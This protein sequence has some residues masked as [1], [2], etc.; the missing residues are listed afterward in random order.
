VSRHVEKA[1]SN[2]DGVI[3]A[4]VARRALTENVNA[5]DE[6]RAAWVRAVARGVPR[7]GISGTQAVARIKGRR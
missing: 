3:P 6:S 2:R 7:Q 4:D 5:D 1:T